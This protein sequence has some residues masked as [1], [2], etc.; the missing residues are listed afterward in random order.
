MSEERSEAAREFLAHA[1]F[2]GAALAPLPGDASTRRYARVALNGR[3]AMLMD[4]PQSAEAPACPSGATPQLRRA[5][6]YNAIARLAGADC[7]RFVA[8]ADYL[9]RKGLSAPEIYA[10]DAVQ[11]FVLMEDLG[12]DL[13]TDVIDKGG[14]EDE[15]YATA[16]EALAHIHAD[17]APLEL[18]PDKTLYAYDKAALM[19]EIDLLTDWYLPLALQRPPHHEEI[20]EHRTEWRNAL[21]ALGPQANVFIHRDYH[22]QNLLWLPGREGHAR[23]GMIDFQD[24][25]SGASSY[26]FVS[27]VEDARRDVAPE[28]GE[29]MMKHYF[30]A[31]KRQGTPLDEELYR[32]E[33]ALMAAQRNAK[34]VGI[35]ARLFSRDSKPRYLSYLPRVWSYLERD[36]EH[37]TL[38][39]LK[40]WY[41]RVIPPASRGVV[42]G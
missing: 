24:A 19:A 11:G 14:D 10:A 28:L 16:V 32:A 39:G 3:K 15:L 23:V 27:L 36:L 7:A 6:G 26:D 34:I 5:L 17:P 38:A 1:G 21:N 22:A 30:E 2:R 25:V 42:G 41:E 12:D 33:M 31:M 35:F 18:S 37:P 9:R 8:A 40:S 4:Q 29:A 13:Y 20:E